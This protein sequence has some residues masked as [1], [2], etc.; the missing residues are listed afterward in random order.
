MS[1]TAKDMHKDYLKRK[2]KEVQQLEHQLEVAQ[3][4]KKRAYERHI[5]PRQDADIEVPAFIFQEWEHRIKEVQKLERQLK[6][7]KEERI[8]TYK[9]FRKIISEFNLRMIEEILKG[10]KFHMLG[11]LGAL[12][13]R[14][15]K[16]KFD[17]PAIDWGETN[18]LKAQGKD[19]IVYHTS[20]YYC[21][22]YWQK[23]TCQ[24]PNK[25]VYYFK[26]TRDNRNQE[27]AVNKLAKLLREDEFAHHNF[28]T[29]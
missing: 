17:K 16:R 25:I 28:E 23:N 5:K 27:G 11:R 12:S 7:K 14:K 3:K 15:V 18:K 9:E 21:R 29:R 13:I 2:K 22:W 1:I 24:V 26:P 4:D 8:L 10:Y 20:D 19:T 6:R